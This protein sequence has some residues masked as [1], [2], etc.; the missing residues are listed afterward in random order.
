MAGPYPLTT[1]AAQVSPTG[2]T[3]PAYSDILASLKASYQLIFGTDA[4]L[5]PDSQDG[6]LLAVFAQAI[7]DCNQTAIATYNQFSPS[8]SQGAGLSSVV[9]INGL[10]RL[11]PTNSTVACEIIGVAG[12]QIINGVVQ[13]VNGNQWSLPT[14]TIPG[15]GSITV[16]ATATELGAVTAASGSVTIATP[17][18]GW[19][20]ATFTSSATAGNPVESDATLRKRQAVSTSLPAQSIIGGIFGTISNIVG[21]TDL[22]IYEN[23]TGTTD[24]NGIPPHSIC[25]VVEGGDAT[26]IATAI[27]EKKTPGTG[28]FGSTTEVIEDPVGLPVTINFQIPTQKTILVDIALTALDGYVSSTGLAIQNAVTA[29]INNLGINANHGLL[30]LSWL[31]SIIYSVQFSTTFNVTSLAIAI[32]PDSPSSADLNIAFDEIPICANTDVTL[33]VT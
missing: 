11:I 2:I 9:K 3:A 1:L 13:D 19:Q 23:D 8:T 32:S 22:V 4:Y 7:Y 5:E 20:S 25:V 26:A 27:E 18:F 29:A 21:V 14:T 28:T 12:T 15:G 10:A 17:I 6:Q 30:S 33:T 16:T 31:Y 24:D